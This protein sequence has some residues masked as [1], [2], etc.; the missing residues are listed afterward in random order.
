MKENKFDL[1]V[2]KES[3]IP[4]YR[5]VSHEITKMIQ[6]GILSYGDKLPP[7]RDLAKQLGTARGTVTK[8]YDHLAKNDVIEIIQGSGCFV[9]KGQYVLLE[10]E[11]TKAI[12]LITANI[13]L[14]ERHAFSHK[15]IKTLFNLVMMER[16]NE[17]SKVKIALVDCNPEAL[18]IFFKQLNYI[19]KGIIDLF[20]L[21]DI[22]RYPR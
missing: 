21:E 7:E 18:T 22:F 19:T 20:L 14:L 4:I 17:L 10:G 1:V 9:A 8:A 5:Q 11:K 12:E 16:E 15:E 6:K 2:D 13:E 3:E